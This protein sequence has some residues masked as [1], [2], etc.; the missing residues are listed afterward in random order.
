MSSSQSYK[1]PPKRNRADDGRRDAP[2][3]PR[4][5][6]KKSKT[7]K[8]KHRG[9]NEPYNSGYKVK[10]SYS[11][12]MALNRE[13]SLHI[14]M[15]YV[16][17]HFKIRDAAVKP[18]QTI[19][20][21]FNSGYIDQ[22]NTMEDDT[23]W[24]HLVLWALLGWIDHWAFPSLEDIRAR[25]RDP[26]NLSPWDEKPAHRERRRKMQQERDE[27]IIADEKKSITGML[28]YDIGY[29]TGVDINFLPNKATH[30]DGR[31]VDWSKYCN[32]KV[33]LELHDYVEMKHQLKDY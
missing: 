23:L 24:T 17:Q 28:N 20:D 7:N 3:K 10:E 16:I 22:V 9:T 8:Q 14:Y 13:A 2:K 33:Y 30:K 25:E 19:V 29:D 27:I 21:P 6:K 5:P 32:E 12:A 4:K 1:T 26:I 11:E 31:P 15:L 18:F